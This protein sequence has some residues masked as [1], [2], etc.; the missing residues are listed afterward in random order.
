MSD[1]IVAGWYTPNYSHWLDGLIPSL[2][3]VGAPHDFVEV[4]PMAD[5]WEANTMRKPRQ[6]ANALSRHPTK[7]VIFLDVDC[8][9]LKPLSPLVM[10]RGD[11]GAYLRTKYRRDGT[12]KSGWRSGTMVFKPTAAARDFVTAW[13]IESERADRYSVDQDSLAVALGRVPGLSITTL[14]VEWC[15]TVGDQCADPAIYHDSASLTTK[16]PRIVRTWH[17]LVGR[18]LA[19]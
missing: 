14:G 16:T 9:V 10:I 5:T 17:R 13:V 2:E 8:T 12:T 1:Y 18:R 11:V 4:A 15:A 6:I 3:A 19:A 7:T